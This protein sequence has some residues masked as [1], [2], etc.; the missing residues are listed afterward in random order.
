MTP[1]TRHFIFI[2]I[3]VETFYGQNVSCKKKET[4]SYIDSQDSK[5]NYTNRYF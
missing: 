4:D 3:I 2:Y 1:G 5:Y